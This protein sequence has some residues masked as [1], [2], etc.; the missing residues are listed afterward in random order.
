MSVLSS[1]K[2]EYGQVG[3]LSNVILGIFGLIVLSIS[4]YKTIINL[5]DIANIELLQEFLVPIL[6][7]I[8]FIPFIYVFFTYCRWEQE[9]VVERIII[10]NNKD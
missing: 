2:S 4:I 1:Y 10:K 3:N 7:S 9:R 6:L 8:M 5:H